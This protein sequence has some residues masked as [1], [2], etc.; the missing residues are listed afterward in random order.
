MSAERHSAAEPREAYGVRGACSRF[1]W[2]LGVRKREQAPRTPY[3]SRLPEGHKFLAACEH[4]GLLRR[5][6][7]L[8]RIFSALTVSLRFNWR[9][10]L[11]WEP[12]AS[13]TCCLLRR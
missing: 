1:R 3:A 12:D 8:F 10:A 11:G 2:R 5:R 13:R 9:A 7:P 4:V 6:D